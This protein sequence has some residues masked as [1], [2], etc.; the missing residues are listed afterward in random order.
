MRG[1][2][3]AV[4]PS[5][6]GALDPVEGSGVVGEPCRFVARARQYQPVFHLDLGVNLG[7]AGDELFCRLAGNLR[8]RGHDLLDQ[9]LLRL[10]GPSA[11]ID[12]V[13]PEIL[14][15]GSPAL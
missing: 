2:P 14:V 7:E 3:G 15:S 11:R 12:P 13:I 1:Q 9:F 5:Q 8:P 4:N 10:Q 6:T